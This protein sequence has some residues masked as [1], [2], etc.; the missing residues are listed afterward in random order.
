MDLHGAAMGTCGDKKRQGLFAVLAKSHRSAHGSCFLRCV[1]YGCVL[2]A[3]SAPHKPMQPSAMPATDMPCPRFCLARP[4]PPSTM[5]MAA[6]RHTPKA[7]SCV[8]GAGLNKVSAAI[9]PHTSAGTGSHNVP[10]PSRAALRC[11]AT[12]A[13]LTAPHWGQL[14]AV[15]WIW[16]PQPI[17]KVM[18]KRFRWV[19]KN[20]APCLFGQGCAPP[21]R[22][23]QV[24]K[25]VRG[26]KVQPGLN[27]RCS[28]QAVRAAWRRRWM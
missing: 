22:W 17:Q 18:V 27:P 11:A 10:S 4:T 7:S 19:D 6:N 25:V 12:P 13:W 21:V 3:P 26:R 15:S 8:Q 14:M 23:A 5:A 2:M 24:Q 28:Y 9:S 1:S 16:W 20:R